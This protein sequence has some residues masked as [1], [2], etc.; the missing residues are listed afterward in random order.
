MSLRVALC[1]SFSKDSYSSRLHW[2]VHRSA[3]I[4]ALVFVG[5]MRLVAFRVDLSFSV[6]TRYFSIQIGVA[7]YLEKRAGKSPNG[8]D[9]ANN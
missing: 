7:L 2:C 3:P 1:T 5:G 9:C 4:V 8:S 6:Y